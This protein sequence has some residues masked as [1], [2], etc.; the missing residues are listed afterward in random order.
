MKLFRWKSL[1][2]LLDLLKEAEPPP[3]Q[4]AFRLQAVERD[5][6]LPVKGIFAL[7][8]CYSFFVS[9]WFEDVTIPRSV[10]Q[11][12]IERFFLLYLAINVGVAIYLFRSRGKL[13]SPVLQRVIFCS[14]FLD[15]VF[16]SS[17]AFVTGGFESLVYWVIPG[18]IVRNALSS[19]LAVPQLL[20][21]SSLILCYVLAGIFDVIVSDQMLDLEDVGA[22][23]H[24]NPTEPFLLRVFVLVLMAACCYGVQIL[25]EKHR[26]AEE[27]ARE[28][29]ARQEKLRSAGRL[30][31][32]IAHQIKNPLAIINNAAFSLERALQE[33]KPPN[34]EQIQII[35]EEVDRSDRILTELMG[36]AQL[37]EGKVEKLRL[38]E[39]LDQAVREVFPDEAQ[40]GT[41]IKR[42]YSPDLPSLLMQRAHLAEILVNV[43]KNARDA[44]DG[45]GGVQ[46]KA[47]PGQD[48][49]ITVIISDQGPGIPKDKQQR[50]F[51]PYFSMKP[52]GTGLGLAIVKNNVE[53][54]GG[55]VKVESELGNG[56]R[57]VINFPTRTFMK[58]QS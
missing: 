51:E 31:A 12:I 52:K 9:R 36:Y 24:E 37:A 58:L 50:I 47:R 18:L 15:G 29:A 5:I 42:A 38:P 22:S 55:S 13:P 27:E 26:Q 43:L 41:R 46:I 56:A 40:Y 4:M 17:L 32:Q 54:Y 11:Q 2:K 49:S 19:P 39:E 23:A 16:L 14:S 35:R 25:L 6:I 20:L 57:F 53:M 28:Y 45:Q 1:G 21:N 3:E 48:Q 8:L 10:A 30:A 7:L 44:M 33:R 34:P